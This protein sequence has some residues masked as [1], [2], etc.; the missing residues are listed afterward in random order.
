M[1][2]SAFP[3]FIS[4]CLLSGPAVA[5][6][7]V[8]V[9]GLS[10]GGK[11]KTPTKHCSPKEDISNYS[12]LCWAEP[13]A[14]L[15]DGGR[16]GILGVPGSDQRPK[17]AAYG[18]FEARVAKDA[19]LESFEIRTPRAD[20]FVEILNSITGRFGQSDKESRPGSRIRSAQWDRSDISIRLLCS[21]DIGCNTTFTSPKLAASTARA[22]AVEKAKDAA[23][24]ASP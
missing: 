14:N 13:P 15:A 3:V 23:R 1:K 24:P 8:I 18:T 5:A 9:L 21:D 12:H 4:L 2:T 11:L 17:W 19:T 22:I 10:V 7:P 20:A 6:E 16:I